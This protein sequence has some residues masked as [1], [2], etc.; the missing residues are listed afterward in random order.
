MENQDLVI[1]LTEK[2][3]SHC[4]DIYQDLEK[5]IDSVE[6]FILPSY[7]DMKDPEFFLKEY[8]KFTSY[9]DKNHVFKVRCSKVVVDI[10]SLL[11]ELSKLNVSTLLKKYTDTLKFHKDKCGAYVK[12]LDSYQKDLTDVLNYFSVVHYTMTTPYRD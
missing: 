7:E 11:H 6:Q 8:S 10:S 1:K 2:L 3:V 5:Y 12:I 4:T 9:S